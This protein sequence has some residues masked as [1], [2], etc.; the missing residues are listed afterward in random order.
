M[1]IKKL[2]MAGLASAVVMFL[3]GGG[4]H[5]ALMGDFYT[6]HS[7]SVAKDPA[8]IIYIVAGYFVLGFIMSYI[9]PQGYKGGTPWMEGLKFG[10]IIGIIWVLPHGLILYAVIESSDR[11]LM[12]VDTAW[13]LVEQ[14]IGGIVIA[15]I[16]G[17]GS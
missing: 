8:N 2:L 16:Y 12:G 3:L 11:T 10:L 9:Y 4:W 1:N 17:R 14:G 6:N 5:M 15:M 7:T 13:H